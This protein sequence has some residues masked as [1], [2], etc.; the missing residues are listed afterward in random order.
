MRILR[1]QFDAGAGATLQAWHYLAD[2]PRAAVFICPALAG[3]AGAYDAFSRYLCRRGMNVWV[4]QHRADR[5]VSLHDWA[6]RDTAT[7]VHRFL[8]AA[9]PLPRWAVGHSFGGLFL[10][11][12]GENREF[13]KLLLV[14][15]PRTNVWS[16]AWSAI[17][18]AAFD[19]YLKVPALWRFRS[20]VALSGLGLDGS[21]PPR[22]AAD[23]SSLMRSRHFERALHKLA[24]PAGN[25]AHFTGDLLSLC[26]RDDPLATAG[27]TRAFAELFTHASR[28]EVR[29]IHPRAFEIA[30][31]SHLGFFGRQ[32]QAGVW[33]A[34]VDGFLAP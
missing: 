10:G 33:P 12:S 16:F 22:I 25:F 34:L 9:G 23:C 6:V 15:S 2:E 7:A 4:H 5:S 31:I 17:P 32:C 11:L 20:R 13:E 8:D 1:L 24:L 19:F 28:C 26:F 30:R 18:R 29:E 21:V 14:A 27:P 3:R